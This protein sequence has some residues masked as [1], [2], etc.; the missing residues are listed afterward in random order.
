MRDISSRTIL[1]ALALATAATL[2]TNAGADPVPNFYGP[3]YGMGPGMMGGYGPGYGMG[4][5]MMGGYGPGY[6][7]GPG[8]MGGYGPGYD[9]NLTSEQRGKIAKLQD[10][11]RRKH[12]DLMGKI[13]DEQS[14]MFE[15]S[16]SEKR[17]DAALSASSRKISDLQHQMFELSLE[18][19]KQMEAV[20]TQEQRAKLRPRGWGPSR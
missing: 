19:R 14:R 7:M 2:G 20:L 12:W 3:G 9:L 4:P 6:G 17:D 18:A 5:G 13:Q 8:M 15:L 10:E 1:C 11:L 16:N